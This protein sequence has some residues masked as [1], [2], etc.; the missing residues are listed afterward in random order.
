MKIEDAKVLVVDD[1]QVMTMFIVNML[2]RLGVRGIG[3]AV[4]GNDGLAKV[5]S[6]RPDVVLTD[7]HMAKMNG[8]E[9]VRQL[10]THSIMELRRT[11]VLIMSAD[12]SGEMLNDALLLGVAG[13]IIKPPVIAAMTTKLEHA[14]KFR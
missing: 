3:E 1:D 14:L 4:D 13:Y 12:S 5:A 2:T 9:F 11:P 8:I 10:R 6:F 7:I